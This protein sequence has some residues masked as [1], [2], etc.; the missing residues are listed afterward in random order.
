MESK[1]SNYTK[2]LKANIIAFLTYGILIGFIFILVVAIIK[3]FLHN[4]INPVLSITLSLI[5]AI[6]I[7]HLMNFICTSSTIETFKNNNIKLSKTDSEKFTKKMNL[8]FIICLLITIIISLA[9]LILDSY[10]Y[11]IAI[12]KAYE[13]YEIISPELA[14]QI[15]NYIKIDYQSKI[16]SKLASTV[17]IESSFVISFINLIHHQNRLLNKYNKRDY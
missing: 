13:Q 2:A 11:L 8:F 15:L 17:I 7:F 6:L 16:L 3:T 9:Y 1:E 10:V 12:N 14:N 5:S 4:V